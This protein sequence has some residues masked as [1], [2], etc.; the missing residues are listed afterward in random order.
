MSKTP[1][2]AED[3]VRML[4]TSWEYPKPI[5]EEVIESAPPKNGWYWAKVR[6]KDPRPS[7]EAAPIRT[8]N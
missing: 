7:M 2:K 1:I 8:L 5:I 6:A 3:E 4:Y